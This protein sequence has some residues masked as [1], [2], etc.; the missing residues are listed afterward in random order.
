MAFATRRR[1]Y[2]GLARL[3]RQ[4]LAARHPGVVLLRIGSVP[5]DDWLTVSLEKDGLTQD[6]AVPDYFDDHP[7][8]RP[9]LETRLK[10]LV[11]EACRRFN[12]PKM[13]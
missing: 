3:V 5:K 9:E 8:H 6:F 12:P 11:D 7:D 4:D 13:D 10:E 1:N 2:D